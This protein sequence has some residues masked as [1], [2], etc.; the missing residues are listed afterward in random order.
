MAIARALASEPLILVLDEAVSALDVSIQAQILNLLAELRGRLRL[1]YV[2]ISHDLAVVRQLADHCLVLYRGTPVES[3][4]VDLILS[5]PQH[6]YTQQLLASVPRP[7]MPLTVRPERL[8]AEGLS[9]CV[10]RNRCPHA[11]AACETEPELVEVTPEHRKACWLP[12][13][14]EELMPTS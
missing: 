4:P 9:G 14:A 5:D 1:T 13:R 8:A 6:P 12:D 3:G 7:G 2:A 10:F 11:F